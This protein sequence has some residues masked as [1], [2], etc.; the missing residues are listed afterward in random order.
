ML[1][2]P[3]SRP[4]RRYL[5]FSVRGLIVLVLVIGA[6]LGWIVRSARMQREAVAAIKNAGGSVSYDWRWSNGNSDF[7]GRG[8]R[9]LIRIHA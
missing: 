6:G 7:P 2:G 8:N 9:G 1:A 4:W 5:R 3:V